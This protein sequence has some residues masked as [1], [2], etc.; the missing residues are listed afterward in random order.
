MNKKVKNNE[1]AA[2]EKLTS[3]PF[4]IYHSFSFIAFQSLPADNNQSKL[5]TSTPLM[6]GPFYFNIVTK[7]D[8]FPVPKFGMKEII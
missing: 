6:V 1:T 4:Y 8:Y 2:V 7:F 5:N 3:S